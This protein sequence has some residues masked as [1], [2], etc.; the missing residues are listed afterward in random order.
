[1]SSPKLSLGTESL[2][3]C[4]RESCQHHEV[5]EHGAGSGLGLAECEA[6]RG[7]PWHALQT[8][9]WP[10]CL[11]ESCSFKARKCLLQEA[12]SSGEVPAP[13]SEAVPAP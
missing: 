7:E 3:V 9:R 4:W 8:M 10:P 13:E 12:T 11:G 1:M 5:P 2:L 6:P